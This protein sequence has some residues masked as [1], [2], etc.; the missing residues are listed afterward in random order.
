MWSQEGTIIC[1]E[2]ASNPGK[3]NTCQL[4]ATHNMEHYKVI[5]KQ[6]GQRNTGKTVWN[7]LD[8]NQRDSLARGLLPILSN[9]ML[10]CKRSAVPSKQIKAS[11][12]HSSEPEPHLVVDVAVA[13]DSIVAEAI[14]MIPDPPAEADSRS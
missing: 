13:A 9:A 2:V 12:R 3:L 10:S 1:K 6:R 5:R 8:S 11:F 4:N 14:S 7:R